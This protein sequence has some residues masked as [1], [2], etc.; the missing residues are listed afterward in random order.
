MI[1]PEPLHKYASA[2]LYNMTLYIIIISQFSGGFKKKNAFAITLSRTLGEV[3]ET[4]LLTGRGSTTSTTE[5][6][7]TI[8]KKRQQLSQRTLDR[9]PRF[10]M[11]GLLD[12]TLISDISHEINST[13][14]TCQERS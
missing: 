2:Y 9:I 13:L 1:Q 12:P 5:L 10:Y 11:P 7:K 3:H 8:V 4:I 6:S 14:L